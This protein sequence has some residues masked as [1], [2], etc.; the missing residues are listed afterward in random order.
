MLTSFDFVIVLTFDVHRKSGASVGARLV[1]QVLVE[2]V[3]SESRDSESHDTI[4]GRHARNGWP[5]RE[6]YRVTWSS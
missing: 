6:Q 4:P 5:K 1:I 3:T 2:K